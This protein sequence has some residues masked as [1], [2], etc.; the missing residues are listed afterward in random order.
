QAIKE[1]GVPITW[2]DYKVGKFGPVPEDIYNKVKQVDNLQKLENGDGSIYNLKISDSP[3]DLPEGLVLNPIKP[4]ND[5]EFSDYE[6][7]ELQAVVDKYGKLTS[8]QLVGMLHQ[9]DTLWHKVV[10]ANNLQQQFELK[11][12][13]SDYVI[14]F[15][16]LLDTDYKKAAF[17][18]AYQSH[19]MQQNLNPTC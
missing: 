10:Q 15:T 11:S 3:V 17:E 12:N 8:E 6:I 18:V 5:D 14:E 1:T 4:F 2:L 19:L 13:R 16:N 9:E 7:G